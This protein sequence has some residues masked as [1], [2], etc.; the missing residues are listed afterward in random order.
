MAT[1]S[2]TTSARIEKLEASLARAKKLKRSEKFDAK[3]MS[4]M[5]GVSWV[6]LRDW[7]DMIAELETSGAVRRGGNGIRWEFSPR[8]TIE[9]LIRHHKAILRGQAARMRTIA[10][11]TG[12]D[13]G[14]DEAGLSIPETKNLVDMTLTVIAAQDRQGAT[15]QMS[16]VETVSNRLCD[17]WVQSVMSGTTTIDPN[18]NLPSHI[19]QAVDEHLRRVCIKAREQVIAEMRN[20]RADLGTKGTGR[21]SA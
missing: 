16:A 2:A 6:T 5:L 8:H 3:P 20:L 10:K 21:A 9:I 7:C 18:G 11:A 12:A 4:E 19:R 14:E 13:V 17:A 1:P 15:C